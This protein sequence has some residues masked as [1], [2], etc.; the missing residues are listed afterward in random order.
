M[1]VTGA[2][3]GL[4]SVVGR[5]G[6]RVARVMPRKGVPCL[7]PSHSRPEDSRRIFWK[8]PRGW[9]VSSVLLRVPVAVAAARPA[10]AAGDM[11]A[12]SAWLAFA[13]EKIPPSLH[14]AADRRRQNHS[15]NHG[16]G[17]PDEPL[18][19]LHPGFHVLPGC[20]H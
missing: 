4:P 20:P 19:A 2:H 9:T 8:L 11:V 18:L 12:A 13:S 7:S 17:D 15:H 3:L 16:R 10:V 14:V 5:I 1:Q 6:R